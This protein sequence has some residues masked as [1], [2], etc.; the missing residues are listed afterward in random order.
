VKTAELR[1]PQQ[2][3]LLCVA[4]ARVLGLLL[5]EEFPAHL[6]EVERSLL[7]RVLASDIVGRAIEPGKLLDWPV[8]G[9]RVVV[10]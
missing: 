6:D 3:S 2:L 5:D 10:A 8:G 9:A 4:K 1:L 7:F